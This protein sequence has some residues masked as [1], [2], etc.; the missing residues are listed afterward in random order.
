[1]KTKNQVQR[2]LDRIDTDTK[3]EVALRHGLLMA[4]EWVLDGSIST[5]VGLETYL[6]EEG[7]GIKLSRIAR[8]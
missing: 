5:S 1:M 3:L 8:R 2:M 4:F 7:S 6:T